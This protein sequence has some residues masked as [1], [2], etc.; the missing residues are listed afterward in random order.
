MK[1]K[2]QGSVSGNIAEI[3]SNNNQKVNRP[4]TESQT[5]FVAASSKITATNAYE[6]VRHK[7][8]EVSENFRTRVS[9]STLLFYDN[10][11]QI[12]AYNFNHWTYGLTAPTT[13]SG[14]LV[15]NDALGVGN[16]SHSAQTRRC[17]PIYKQ[18]YTKVE[19]NLAVNCYPQPSLG[20]FW[21]LGYSASGASGQLANGFFFRYTITGK[22]VCVVANQNV[23]RTSDELNA[24]ELLGDLN[25]VNNF[26]IYCGT[27]D[28]KFYINR[29][30]VWQVELNG[31]N[32]ELV[33]SRDHRVL[34]SGQANNNDTARHGIIP[35]IRM[36]AVSVCLCEVGNGK[37]LAHIQGGM[38]QSANNLPTAAGGQTS[39]YTNSLAA[40]AGVALSNTTVNA[41]LVGL[42]GQCAVLPTLTA[43]TDGI[44][45][46][47]LVPASSV[48][49]AGKTLYITGIRVHGAVTTALTGGAVIYDYAVAV[50]S[51]AVSAATT[52]SAVNRAP[53]RMPIGIST[54]AANATVGTIG[55]SV[56]MKFKTP[57]TVQQGQYFQV[58]AKN[59]GTVTSAG[60][61]THLITVDGYWE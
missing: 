31:A 33:S 44:L 51:S 50:G 18:F 55:Q 21:G 53:R 5:G 35:M 41:A 16:M 32:S 1:I 13:R 46:S 25:R 23:E 15:L 17:F 61:I 43:G 37:S 45:N 56:Y 22:F 12:Q 40:G 58:L 8:L 49:I 11:H 57:I 34:L 19:F 47:Y 27:N 10:F 38:S 20:L 29:V 26:E 30:L 42:G 39:N 2:I 4:T 59:V 54:Y 36:S 24:S 60:V 3:D 28:A 48:T 6:N 9:Q 14:F 52:D 7:A